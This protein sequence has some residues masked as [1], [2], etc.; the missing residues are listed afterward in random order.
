VGNTG[1]RTWLGTDGA[2]GHLTGH[3][4]GTNWAVYAGSDS[5][6]AMV[7]GPYDTTYGQGHHTAQFKL[8]VDNN[9]GS[10]VIGSLDVVTGYGGNVLA[11]RQ[12]RRS[13]FSAANQWQTFT[14]QFDN[15]CFGLFE[16]RV[17]WAGN[18]NMKFAQ[19]TITP[20]DV[21]T[22]GV[23]WLVTDQLGTPRMV[24]DK[25]GNF[26]GVS[27]HDYLP[28]GEE[29]YAGT[30]GRTS[31]EGYNT[32]NVRQH[33][34][35]YEAD[36]ETGLN[37]AQARYQSP[38]QGRF[39]SVDPLG[40]SANVLNPQSF[41]RY[42]YV[43]NDPLN[44]TDPSGLEPYRGADVGWAQFAQEVE[45]ESIDPFRTHFGGPE[46]L[47]HALRANQTREGN[48]LA[49]VRAKASGYFSNDPDAI[50]TNIEAFMSR[51]EALAYYRREFGGPVM[52][53]QGKFSPIR[54]SASGARVPNDPP[55][56]SGYVDI[57]VSYGTLY[58]FLGPTGGVLIDDQGLYPYVGG[59]FISPGP[60]AMVSYSSDRVSGGLN[61]QLQGGPVSIGMD[62]AGNTFQELGIPTGP[63]A[64]ATVFY[65]FGAPHPAQ[66][67]TRHRHDL[68]AAINGGRGAQRGSSRNCA[69][70]S[71]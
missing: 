5:A 16:A 69:C 44:D 68:N 48:W 37:F 9:S 66:H 70:N 63:S 60:S 20:L 54:A 18:A 46:V 62:E 1:S 26:N 3:A 51:D 27:R 39:T 32:D 33:F 15:P 61:G 17:W 49:K 12:V 21:A 23:Q 8:M 29:V 34:T 2:L 40:R 55:R 10:D 45:G 24:F 65:V 35:G 13:D 30:G 25:T 36:G 38:V 22:S 57:N 56:S 41:N 59:G 4:E 64:S 19:L 58:Y 50:V 71:R 52:E 31:A 43:E 14:L 11:T 7:F 6:T 47:G 42:S 67:P 53:F 28:F